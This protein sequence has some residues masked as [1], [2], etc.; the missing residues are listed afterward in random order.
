MG[1]TASKPSWHGPAAQGN[2][3]LQDFPYFA[4]TCL[5]LFQNLA[6][7]IRVIEYTQLECKRCFWPPHSPALEKRWLGNELVYSSGLGSSCF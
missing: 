7:E 3:N 4:F 6:A 2:I 1:C 5:K